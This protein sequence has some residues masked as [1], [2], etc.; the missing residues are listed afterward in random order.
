MSVIYLLYQIL[1]H[2]NFYYLKGSTRF[3]SY[4]YNIGSE[5][6]TFEDA[7]KACS[8]AGANLVDV[9]DRWSIFMFKSQKWSEI[10]FS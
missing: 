6:K 1:S 2:W 3:G 8:E 4:C 10:P 9:A 7:K 5:T